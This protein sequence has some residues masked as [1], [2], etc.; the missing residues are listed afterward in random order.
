[1]SFKVH[2]SMYI[3]GVALR[4]K[5]RRLKCRAIFFY[6]NEIAMKF[7]KYVGNLLYVTFSLYLSILVLVQIL[8]SFP[9][10][11]NLRCPPK[12]NRVEENWVK[13]PVF[14]RRNG[15]NSRNPFR[16]KIRFKKLL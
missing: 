16:R 10:E 12:P 11:E 9:N 14:V 4:V 15:S 5:T 3:C 13:K 1:M 2:L 6:A 8:V 7:S